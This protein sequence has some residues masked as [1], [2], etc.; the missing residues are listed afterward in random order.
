V[1]IRPF[2]PGDELAISEIYNHYITDTVVTFEEQ[3]LSPAQMRERIDAYTAHHPWLVAEVDGAI[4][5]YCY[6]A[7]F[8]ARAAYRHTAELTV[9]LR[10]GCERRGLGRR[11]YA[12]LLQHLQQQGCHALLAAIALP[13]AGSVGLH[14]SLGFRK[15]G[16]L[17]E[18]GY[19]LGR[20]VD[21]GYWQRQ[22]V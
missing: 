14:E 17:A 10:R 18:V 1:Q 16:H 19:K 22:L 5:G 15:V 20:W 3:P 6:A 4:A 8:H 2:S 21:V 11:L 12:P 13:N 9:Y 7:K